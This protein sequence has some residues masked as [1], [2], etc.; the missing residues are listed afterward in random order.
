MALAFSSMPFLPA[1]TPL[2]YLAM[3]VAGLGSAVVRPIITA[4]ITLET[5]EPQGVTMGTANAFESLG[6]LVGPLLGGLLLGA[7][8]FS[9]PFVFSAFIIV[10]VLI[11]IY[12]KTNFAAISHT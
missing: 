12:K 5:K 8:G 6:R 2:F 3:A 10:V 9:V 1:V 4:L 11:F 7:F